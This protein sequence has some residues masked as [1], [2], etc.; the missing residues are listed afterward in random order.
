MSEAHPDDTEALRQTN[1]Y[2]AQIREQLQHAADLLNTAEK[3]FGGTY[4]QHL[5]EVH[6]LRRQSEYLPSGYHPA[7]GRRR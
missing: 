6:N 2:P 5:V 3:V 4:V 7:D 1:A